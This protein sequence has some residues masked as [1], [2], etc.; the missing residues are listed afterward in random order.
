VIREEE[1]EL[2][3]PGLDLE[4]LQENPGGGL[5]GNPYPS[6][7]H[8]K[9]LYVK[10]LGL[11]DSWNQYANLLANQFRELHEDSPQ[12]RELYAS[13]APHFSIRWEG[14]AEHSPIALSS[15]DQR[16]LTRLDVGVQG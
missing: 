3:W 9:Y 6:A 14:S 7:F 1:Y 5:T 11:V 13:A 2:F 10:Y 16:G 12:R 4:Y 8:S 15:S